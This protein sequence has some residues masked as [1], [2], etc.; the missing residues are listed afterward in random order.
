MSQSFPSQF[1][2][3]LDD[4]EKELLRRIFDESESVERDSETEKR[5]A[6]LLDK[7]DRL[8]NDS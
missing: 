3:H 2:R 6:R 8:K 1:L 4:A 7:I 5:I